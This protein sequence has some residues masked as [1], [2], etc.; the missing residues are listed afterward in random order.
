MQSVPPSAETWR[1][2]FALFEH[3][4]ALEPAARSRELSQLAT[5]SPEL[6]A[7][8]LTLLGAHRSHDATVIPGGRRATDAQAASDAPA[9][10][11][12]FGPYRL[13]R[14]LGIG[15]M[16]E[17]WLA[18]RSDGRFDGL[19][20][21]KILH[22]HIAQSSARERFLREGRIL[23]HLSHPNIARLLDAGSTPLG[24][25]YLVLEYV[26]EGVPIDIWCDERKLDVA[27]RL[28]LFLQICA[29]VS[30]AHAHLV[31]H[32]D[33]K[34]PNILVTRD[35]KIKLLD[36]GIAKLLENEE[37]A[38]E[39]ELTRLGGRAMTPDFAAPEQILGLP[40]TTSTDVYSLGVLLYLLLCGRL[41]HQRRQRSAHEIEK[42]L[43]EGR[44]PTLS[45]ALSSAE[46]SDLIA[47]RRA[48]TTH[49]L[50]RVLTGDLDT[51]VHKALRIEPDRRYKS[52][53]QLAGDIH[54]YLDGRPV[55]AVRDTWAY[56]ARKFLS[57]HAVGAAIASMSGILL[58][59]FVLAMF[60]QMQRTEQQRLRAER[61]SSFLV[62]LFEQS[63]PYKTRSN[64]V[65]AR[66]LLDK[67]A[68]RITHGLM[69]HPETLAALTG[70]IGQIYT[71]LGVPDEAIPLLQRARSAQEA[72]NGTASVQAAAITNELGVAFLASG[73]LQEAKAE[74]ERALET[75]KQQLG[76]DSPEVAQTLM[77]LGSV[78][79]DSGDHIAAETHF[80]DSL[81]IQEQL[82]RASSGDAATAML[83]LANLLSHLGRYEESIDLLQ[84][85]LQIDRA[86]LGDDHPRTIMEAHS[87]AYA[88][89]MEGDFAAAEPLFKDSNE[90]IR[91][92]LGPDHPYT[93]D[94]LS[95]YARFLRRRGNIEQAE[96][97]F[98][99]V[100]EYNIRTRGT[101][102]PNVGTARANLA[103]LLHDAGRLNEA[104]RE[105]EA[106]I[107][108]YSKSLPPEHP[109][110][111][112]V[113]SGLGR[114]LVDEGRIHD[115]LPM[116]E[117]AVEISRTTMTKE[118][119]SLAIAH[120][121]LASA[122]TRLQRYEEAGV[123]LTGSYD[124]V[125]KTQGADSAVVRH[126][127]NARTAVAQARTQL[128][129]DDSTTR[130][131][132]EREH[133]N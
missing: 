74:L 63:D 60:L 121:S 25:S 45:R 88:L 78:A 56:R 7:R 86:A 24:V 38:G 28:N 49:K 133:S 5:S 65:T 1:Q 42:D 106:A 26:E 96:P 35:G 108:S 46:E 51:I 19:V 103:I 33:L 61:V 66:E 13:L 11:V 91:R 37:A 105:F 52:V 123:L 47:E 70:T 18:R 48:T 17:V 9:A 114:V 44:L 59:A 6:Y 107:D 132:S 118:S 104:E 64:L 68:E 14:Q 89:Q 27:A 112:S 102:H 95:N 76:A 10:D 79:F 2:A 55:T 109:S 82:G 53:E 20:A 31:I 128:A 73:R 113:Y 101:A 34:P 69:D 126:A 94:M 58:A 115:G 111:I 77:N 54:R 98:R 15:G 100:V 30:H 83:E 119:P 110:F 67:G 57:R 99:E 131:P 81:S 21:V 29:A 40:V 16:G 125:L 71:R 4:A 97:L 92:T 84:R 36:F 39:T 117:R 12:R 129:Q 43:L 130:R 85:A 22:A 75:R 62:E 72:I 120:V 90:R 3:I 122:L 127:R 23:G 32:R 41:P 116:L 93:I 87:L 80:R 8:V 124:I 50:K